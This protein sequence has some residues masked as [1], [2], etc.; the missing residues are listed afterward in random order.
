MNCGYCGKSGCTEKREQHVFVESGLKNVTLANV[1]VRRCD[2]CGEVEVLIPRLPELH[3]LLAEML[4]RKESN[5]AAEE[6]RFLRKHLGYSS[7]DF[8]K[9]LGVTPET[10]S[11]WESGKHPLDPPADRLIRMMVATSKPVNRYPEEIFP[12]QVVSKQKARPKAM[13]LAAPRRETGA[14]AL[15]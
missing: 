11:R 13:H 5:L 8:A 3:R 10:I 2:S 14:W 9:K 6:F 12:D 4:I 7:S 1:P 15:A